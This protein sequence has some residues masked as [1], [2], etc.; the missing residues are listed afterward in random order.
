VRT[1]SAWCAIK[2]RIA[3]PPESSQLHARRTPHAYHDSVLALCIPATVHAYHM[4]A[5][6]HAEYSKAA[7]AA[8][9]PAQILRCH[10]KSYDWLLTC[11]GIISQTSTAAAPLAVAAENIPDRNA[12]RL[13]V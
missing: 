13:R 11:H 12:L 3:S 1:R 5:S 6:T 7:V 9:H 2:A 10:L 4:R 8:L